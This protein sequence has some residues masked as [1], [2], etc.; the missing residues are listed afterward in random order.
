MN[1]TKTIIIEK[2]VVLSCTRLCLF[3]A[4]ILWERGV[5]MSTV[6]STLS[7]FSNMMPVGIGIKTLKLYCASCWV[8]KN[9]TDMLLGVVQIWTT[10]KPK[11]LLFFL[12]RQQ[13]CSLASKTP[14]VEVREAW[15]QLWLIFWGEALKPFIVG[16]QVLKYY[17]QILTGHC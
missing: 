6:N 16:C 15:A 5:N 9:M 7:L 3:C 12:E 14:R 1:I 17:L 11:P 13:C 8:M 10:V 2:I 4:R